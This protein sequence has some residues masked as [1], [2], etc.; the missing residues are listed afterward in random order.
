MGGSPEKDL[1]R[2]DGRSV[3]TKYCTLE[4]RNDQAAEEAALRSVIAGK[5]KLSLA[6]IP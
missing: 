5:I 6:L 3:R 2:T 1:R 4:L